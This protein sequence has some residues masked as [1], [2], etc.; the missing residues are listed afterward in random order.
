M[1]GLDGIKYE[2]ILAWKLSH[3]TVYNT[4]SDDGVGGELIIELNVIHSLKSA[5]IISYYSEDL[6]ETIYRLWVTWK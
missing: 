3:S 5:F 4:V 2:K 6:Q 1:E